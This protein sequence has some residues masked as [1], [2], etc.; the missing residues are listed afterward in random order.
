MSLEHEQDQSLQKLANSKALDE[1]PSRE[2]DLTIK[3]GVDEFPDIPNV[4]RVNGESPERMAMAPIEEESFDQA[5]VRS[6]AYQ[7]QRTPDFWAEE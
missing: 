6:T 2:I 3:R 1:T 4:A 5:E 7:K